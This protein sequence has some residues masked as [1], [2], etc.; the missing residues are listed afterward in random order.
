[1]DWILDPHMIHVPLHYCI[2]CIAY[3]KEAVLMGQKKEVAVLVS[4]FK[5]K[6]DIFGG[7]SNFGLVRMLQLGFHKLQVAAIISRSNELK[8]GKWLERVQYLLV[9]VQ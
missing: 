6:W 9:Q 7:Y 1:M 8:N 3:H 2:N 4:K 5:K